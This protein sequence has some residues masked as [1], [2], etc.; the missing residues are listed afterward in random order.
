M[1]RKVLGPEDW[2][3]HES[4]NP[5]PQPG[6]HGI[7]AGPDRQ[8]CGVNGMSPVPRRDFEVLVTAASK[9]GAT[10]EISHLIAGTLVSEGITTS[11]MPV[12]EV[13]SIN[14]YDAVVVGSAIY[15]G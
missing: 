9:R 14:Q 15:G 10:A 3:S 13:V 6:R 2:S 7:A 12:E 5:V 4:Q 11:L 8:G 1:S